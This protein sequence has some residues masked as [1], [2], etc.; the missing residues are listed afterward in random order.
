MKL[1]IF[2]GSLLL[3]SAGFA[4]AQT[5]SGDTDA[6]TN[7]RYNPLEA[8][9]TTG[10]LPAAVYSLVS[11]TS[12]F[13]PCNKALALGQG[14][15]GETCNSTYNNGPNPPGSTWSFGGHGHLTFGPPSSG[16]TATKIE[17]QFW[18]GEGISSCTGGTSVT[19]PGGALGEDATF[20]AGSFNV[21]VPFDWGG[22]GSINPNDSA[23][24]VPFYVFAKPIGGSL[25]CTNN[26]IATEENNSGNPTPTP[27]PSATPTS[28]PSATPTPTLDV[29]NIQ[30]HQGG[31]P[32]ACD[33]TLLQSGLFTQVSSDNAGQPCQLGLNNG[34]CDPNSNWSYTVHGH[35]TLTTSGLSSK[36]TSV[37]VQTYIGGN[38]ISCSA[39]TTVS[40]TG[41]YTLVEDSTYNLGTTT[42]SVPF[43]MGEYLLP[44]NITGHP[45]NFQAYFV[46]VKPMQ[47][48][49]NCES[50]I[51]T[52]TEHN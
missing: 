44:A 41:S 39:G 9:D 16:V 27:N 1:A 7:Q 46:F 12:S 14:A 34:L 4:W 38:G 32:K 17:V 47:G 43:D 28:T 37:E 10:N 45:G 35:L 6:V 2:A 36:A 48:L 23:F 11:S 33:N 49:L 13:E 31:G 15:A 21:S 19:C 3:L 18:Y 24:P 20:P 52:T 40:C 51:Y 42:L 50:N 8:C 22:G 30:T 5:F 26:N 25:Q 29:T